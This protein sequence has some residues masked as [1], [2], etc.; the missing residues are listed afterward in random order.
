MSTCGHS[1]PAMNGCPREKLA[2]VPAYFTEVSSSAPRCFVAATREPSREQAPQ[3]R[4]RARTA[5]ARAR[6]MGISGEGRDAR[7]AGATLRKAGRGRQPRASGRPGFLARGRRAVLPC[8]TGAARR[9]RHTSMTSSA[10][11]A[12]RLAAVWFADIVGYTTLSQEDE[13]GALKVV[14]AFQRICSEVVP[15]YSGRIVKYIGDAALAE[16]ASTDGA[17]RS[18]LALME[19]FVQDPAAAPR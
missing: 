9:L 2:P 19:R 8:S 11:P 7:G 12:R 14:N 3:A 5:W 15:Q 6:G 13:D 16:F 1:C 4:A 17:I 10:E 18:A